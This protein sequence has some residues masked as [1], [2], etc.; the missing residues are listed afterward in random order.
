MDDIQEF[1]KK[2]SELVRQWAEFFDK[3]YLVLCDDD[4]NLP[5]KAL[6]VKMLTKA[7]KN[8]KEV[9]NVYSDLLRS[10]SCELFPPERG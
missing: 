1:D 10:K 8:L 5:Q 7:L 2:L 6:E 3:H 9:Q 4:G